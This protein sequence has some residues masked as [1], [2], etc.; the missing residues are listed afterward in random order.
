MFDI[1]IEPLA[2]ALRSSPHI[3]GIVRN[4]IEQRTSLY[5]DDLLLY[6]SDISTSIP[7]ILDIFSS[8]GPISGYKLNVDKSES[9]PLNAAARNHCWRRG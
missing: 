7:A 4:G 5:A 6:I 1:A 2:I 9:L 3:T 8:F